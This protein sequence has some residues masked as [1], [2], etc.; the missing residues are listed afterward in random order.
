L[1]ST[2]D[3]ERLIEIIVT[4]GLSLSPAS[5]S[6]PP[7]PLQLPKNIQHSSAVALVT[8]TIM[9]AGFVLF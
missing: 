2:L 8:L 9:S 7:D 1:S 3:G 6:P 5:L 4:G